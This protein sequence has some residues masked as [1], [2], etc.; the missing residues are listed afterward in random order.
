MNLKALLIALRVRPK[1]ALL[2]AIALGIGLGAWLNRQP[3]QVE[4]TVRLIRHVETVYRDKPVVHISFVDRIVWR[5]MKADTVIVSL[6]GEVDSIVVSFCAPDTSRAR[7]LLLSGRVGP[8]R[9]ELFGATSRGEAWRGTWT[10]S[11]SYQFVAEGD[12]VSVQA[13]RLQFR[14]PTLVSHGVIAAAAFGLGVLVAK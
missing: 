14:L 11:P 5:T 7:V 6:P 9:L 13:H 10:I 1:L 2:A 12:S 4:E 8:R 3:A